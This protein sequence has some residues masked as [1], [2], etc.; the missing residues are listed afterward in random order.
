MEYEKFLE[1]HY[2]EKIKKILK[3]G[4]FGWVENNN[5]LDVKTPREHA[6]YL[7][8][9]FVHLE[10]PFA[11]NLSSS[12]RYEIAQALSS[13]NMYDS[14]DSDDEKKEDKKLAKKETNWTMLFGT[15]RSEIWVNLEESY[16]RFLKEFPERARESEETDELRSVVLKFLQGFYR[17][18]RKEKKEAYS[19]GW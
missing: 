13:V 19:K 15:A 17:D 18:A 5:W 10:A 1:R 6:V 7:Y 8:E 2:P 16:Q 4:S 14:S 11:L 12:T 9:K 3:G